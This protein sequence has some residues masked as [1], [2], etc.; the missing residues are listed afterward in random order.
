MSIHECQGQTRA[1]N[2][3][4]QARR[5]GRVAHGY[6][7]HGPSGVGKNLLAVQWAKLMLCASPVRRSIEPQ[8]EPADLRYSH[9]EI[10]DCCDQC[11]ECR[12]ADAGT[13]PDL[14]RIHKDL[15]RH[16]RQGRDRQPISLPI[17]VIREFVIEPAGLHPQRG[18]ARVFVV[19][20]ADAMTV[21]SQNALLKT[22]E[23]PPQRTFIILISSHRE[24]L[25]ATIRSR[26]QSIRFNP[27]PDDLIQRRLIQSGLPEMQ[28]QYWTQ[29][30]QGR[31]GDALRL[32]RAEIYPIK[33]ELVEQLSRLDYPVAL[34]LAGWIVEQA[35]EYA[36]KYAD[37]QSQE[38]PGSAVR[39][40]YFLL[41]RMLSQAFSSAMRSSVDPGLAIG[42]GWDQPVALKKISDRFGP[43]RCAQAIRAT[44]HAGNLIGANVNPALI[45]ES[46]LLKYID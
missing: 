15:I 39:Q 37:E 24:S 46:L 25:L 20:Q 8:D 5:S 44:H 23:E 4:Q 19:D 32:G 21:A 42:A 22:L 26:C 34:E 29:F 14:H 1:V 3:L 18:R 17:D 35:K 30:C 11:E 16:A 28:A 27:L 36:A 7:F 13:H 40:G 2:Q 43:G 6:I 31:L 45:F 9:T 33:C 10:D 38:S 41:L 12:L